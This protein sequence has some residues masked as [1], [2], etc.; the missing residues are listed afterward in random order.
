MNE[1]V[2][3]HK[4]RVR[5]LIRAQELK[6]WWVAEFSGVHKTTLRRWLNGRI[7]RVQEQHLARLAAVL[8]VS[9]DTLVRREPTDAARGP[10]EHSAS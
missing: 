5:E 8:S 9:P 10:R 2:L 6:K 1:L 4:D 3:L 7:D